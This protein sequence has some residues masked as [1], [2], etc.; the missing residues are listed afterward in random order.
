MDM[1]TGVLTDVV[2]APG[3]IEIA[4]LTWA[5]RDGRSE[6]EPRPL[7]DGAFFQQSRRTFLLRGYPAYFPEIREMNVL[8]IFEPAPPSMSMNW[9]LRAAVA[10]KNYNSEV[11][12]WIN[13]LDTVAISGS[14]KWRY[15][16]NDSWIVTAWRS[17][18]R[19]K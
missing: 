4:W 15:E 7:P 10:L 9:F 3:P 5:C 2:I 18:E 12:D 13:W 17:K 11:R 8:P 6:M 19:I 14:V 16:E 1:Y